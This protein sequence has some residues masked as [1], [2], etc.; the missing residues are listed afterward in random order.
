[1]SLAFAANTTVNAATSQF[2]GKSRDVSPEVRSVALPLPCAET[3]QTQVWSPPNSYI[4]TNNE[5]PTNDK[6]DN[7]R[8]LARYKIIKKDIGLAVRLGQ[9]ATARAKQDA[10]FF[11]GKCLMCATKNPD[12]T[13]KTC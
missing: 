8:Y 3:R 7:M 12:S 4:N 10:F 9:A 13:F 1:M 5:Q 6:I 11:R 2:G